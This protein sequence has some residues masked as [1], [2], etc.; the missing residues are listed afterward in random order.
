MKRKTIGVLLTTLALTFTAGVFTACGSSGDSAQQSIV[1][2]FDVKEEI[3][4]TSGSVVRPETVFATDANG[5]VLDVWV[6]VTT[7]DGAV[8]GLNANTF[9]ADYLGGYTITYVV[10]T[11]N[12]TTYR[13][14]TKVKVLGGA[15]EVSLTAEYESIVEVGKSTLIVPVCSDDGATFDYTVTRGD[16]E[17][18]VTDGEFVPD[19]FGEYTVT[20]EAT[21][22]DQKAEYSYKIFAR[23]PSP[24][25][26]I[27][28]YDEEWT[29]YAE[30]IGD[31]RATS[32]EIVDSATTGV[33]N[34][35]GRDDTFLRL[36]T[37]DEYPRLFLLPRNDKAYY[38][39]LAE[40]GYEYLSTW[41]YIEGTVNHITQ[42]SLDRST[43]SFF[44]YSGPRLQAG[45]WTQV[46]YRLADLPE[47]D[48]EKSFISAYDDYKEFATYFILVDNSDAYNG[49]DGHED[50]IGI[51]F[52]DFYAVKTQDVQMKEGS[53]TEYYI[54]D[55]WK[56]S[57]MF[58]EE[59]IEENGLVFSITQ[60]GETKL[61]SDGFTFDK[62]SEYTVNVATTRG[63]YV[64]A[65]DTAITT[66][67][68]YKLNTVKTSAEI[69]T[70]AALDFITEFGIS[71]PNETVTGWK[72][73][74]DSPEI[75]VNGATCS[76]AFAGE[77]DVYLTEFTIGDETVKLANPYK[78]TLSV[79]GYSL[80][81]EVYDG[82]YDNRKTQSV[83]M[84]GLGVAEPENIPT[85]YS[86]GYKLFAVV[87]D[88][89]TEVTG[90]WTDSTLTL[91]DLQ[92]KYV[93]KAVVQ[94]GDSYASFAELSM[95]V[96][97]DD[98][99]FTSK[100]A[101]ILG[102]VVN[103]SEKPENIEN[104][105]LGD[106]DGKSN[107][108]KIYST[109]HSALGVAVDPAFSYSTIQTLQN[110][111]LGYYIVYQ[112]KIENISKGKATYNA[113]DVGQGNLRNLAAD[114][115]H[116]VAMPLF[117]AMYQGSGDRYQGRYD[118]AVASYLTA[119]AGKGVTE[120]S[121]KGY[122]LRI[123][124]LDSAEVNIYVTR[125][126]LECKVQA[127]NL[128]DKNIGSGVYDL[129][130]LFD[131]SRYENSASAFTKTW[132][133]DDAELTGDKVDPNTLT[134]GAHTLKLVVKG[135]VGEYITVRPITV[136]EATI[137]V[138]DSAQGV[139]WASEISTANAK[140]F[141]YTKPQS[142][143]SIVDASE[144][145]TQT[146]YTPTGKYYK[147]SQTGVEALSLWVKPAY[148]LDYYKELKSKGFTAIT[149]DYYVKEATEDARGGIDWIRWNGKSTAAKAGETGAWATAELSLD[150]VIENWYYLSSGSYKNPDGTYEKDGYLLLGLFTVAEWQS[151][152]IEFYVGNFGS[153]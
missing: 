97:G 148:S 86:V 149:F 113:Y 14:Q 30:F 58:D 91:T 61:L 89:E 48:Y 12:N 107:V 141:N 65:G 18:E 128:V 37:S 47:K 118:H 6:E 67:A 83:N 151:T 20:I 132:S 69:A 142:S 4:V 66:K 22:G 88:E 120:T 104:T 93:A 79:T 73:E 75:T 52:S 2:G 105:Y 25:G 9:N 57:D 143:L 44:K 85:G 139:V 72:F 28:I 53:K 134:T 116:T 146:G 108:T 49:T 109:K 94:K 125:P 35:D 45:Q 41:I 82:V 153:K 50:N 40:E 55:T 43:N 68:T 138:Y 96:Y 140:V 31:T 80:T 3:S 32:W 112:F 106:F 78:F 114:E 46:T 92:G 17:Y 71:V 123:N 29:A 124:N 10:R 5:N 129:A 7:A 54:G 13:K 27:E 77:Y 56:A 101:P 126:T 136:Y 111:G 133:L 103:K 119:Q 115:W 19:T 24:K 76:A 70:G 1:L 42:L 51:Y 16:A 38:E 87:G 62:N 122:L 144:V 34:R 95:E 33:K 121:L 130:P 74:T 64:L 147:V 63:D 26:A 137:N 39:Q 21:A 110:T 11:E 90:T 81:A 131:T 99:F 15:S 145:P 98:M 127:E 36:K 60:N 84:L 59:T 117:D 135:S 102:T 23:N 100:H 8:V 150:I 152:S